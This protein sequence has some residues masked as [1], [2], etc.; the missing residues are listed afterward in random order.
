VGDLAPEVFEGEYHGNQQA[1][2]GIF[3][4]LEIIVSD[5]ERTASTTAE[6]EAAAEEEFQ[7]QSELINDEI[8][9]K[10][11]TKTE[12]EDERTVKEAE[13]VDLEDDL[14]TATKLHEQAMESLEKLQASCVDSSESWEERKAQ[15]EKEIEALKQALTI[16]D[17]WKS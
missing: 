11:K 7:K 2:K 17:E 14:K 4:L 12:K 1:S 10:D 6:R 3:G 16:L 15:R 5:F 9:T 8:T 13:I